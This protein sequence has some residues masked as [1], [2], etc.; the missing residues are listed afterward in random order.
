[1][2]DDQVAVVQGI[3]RRERQQGGGQRDPP[4]GGQSGQRQVCQ[5]RCRREEPEH[6]QPGGVKLRRQ[7]VAEGRRDQ[8][9]QRRAAD[10]KAVVRGVT[11]TGRTVHVA[12]P[13]EQQEAVCG[14]EVRCD[15]EVI[16]GH[17]V[18]VARPVEAAPV[19]GAE[20]EDGRQRR[21][22]EHE[23]RRRK[24]REPTRAGR[25]C[26]GGHRGVHRRRSS[27]S[28]LSAGV[29]GRPRWLQSVLARGAA[30]DPES[31]GWV[32]RS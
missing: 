13:F 29:E 8:R 4:T 3:I 18:V 28:R 10:G 19:V 9:E 31:A 24:P 20:H 14:R 16:R 7:V 12:Q 23:G 32:C 17:L 21:Q 22:Q 15:R 11:G 30:G 5:H 25:E 26:D 1:M 6:Q 27:G 2:E